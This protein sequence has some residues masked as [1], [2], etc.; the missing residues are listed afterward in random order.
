MN[1]NRIDEIGK[2]HLFEEELCLSRVG[3]EGRREQTLWGS[4]ACWCLKPS[5]DS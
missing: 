4:G 1:S 3:E 2:V 5:F